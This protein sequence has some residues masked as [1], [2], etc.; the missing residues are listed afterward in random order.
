[1]EYILLPHAFNIRYYIWTYWLN[2]K[3]HRFIDNALCTWYMHF[4]QTNTNNDL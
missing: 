1:M 3:H 2:A 4:I